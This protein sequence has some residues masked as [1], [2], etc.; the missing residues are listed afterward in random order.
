MQLLL[1]AISNILIMTVSVN[2]HN[3]SLSKRGLEF[4]IIYIII[5][6]IL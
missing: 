5:V 6:D 4:G 1:R 3:S 2:Q